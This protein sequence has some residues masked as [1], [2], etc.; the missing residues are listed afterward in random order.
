MEEVRTSSTHS[1]RHMQRSAISSDATSYAKTGLE[2]DTDDGERA[3]ENAEASRALRATTNHIARERPQN[4]EL[5]DAPVNDGRIEREFCDAHRSPLQ[6]NSRCG[7]RRGFFD[8][9]GDASIF[10]ASDR[11]IASIRIL[12]RRHWIIFAES[13][14]GNTS[15][16]DTAIFYEPILH[17]RWRVRAK[18][19]C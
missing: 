18:A 1:R 9:D 16:R 5:S 15:R 3:A 4:R 8:D 10:G 13:F 6:K 11:I 19:A 7:R 14:R 2:H 12:V 17:R